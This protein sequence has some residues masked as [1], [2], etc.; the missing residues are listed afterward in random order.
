MTPIEQLRADMHG[1]AKHWR[2]RTCHNTEWRTDLNRLEYLPALMDCGDPDC[3]AIRDCAD[4]L[5]LLA[6]G[7]VGTV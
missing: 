2:D 6:D 4:H 7:K 1:L 5:D 3:R